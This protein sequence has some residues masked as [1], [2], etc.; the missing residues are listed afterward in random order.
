MESWPQTKCS[1]WLLPLPTLPGWGLPS[2][3]S[4]S[5][6]FR[7]PKKV[8]GLQ[9]LLL[10]SSL[11]NMHLLGVD[12]T[13]PACYSPRPHLL[14]EETKERVCCLRASKCHRGV[15][16]RLGEEAFQ[17]ATWFQ[18][19]VCI[20]SI[21]WELECEAILFLQFT[22]GTGKAGPLSKN[23]AFSQPHTR[24]EAGVIRGQGWGWE[25]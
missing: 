7:P 19:F 18:C 15:T 4:S 3:R 21:R 14:N 20:W 17:N 9:L 2:W 6:G 22:P 16:G 25:P 12:D 24:Q 13:Y 23:S 5:E 10:C 11:T 8:L 1:G